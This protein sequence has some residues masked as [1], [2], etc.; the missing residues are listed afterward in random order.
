MLVLARRKGESIVISGDIEVVVLDVR[1]DVVKL[2]INAPASVWV[3][4]KEVYEE[5][6]KENQTAAN[7]GQSFDVLK[8]ITIQW[9][10]NQ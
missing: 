5:I 8:D 10:E 2:G 7:I 6:V 3:H 9:E 4:R 1:G